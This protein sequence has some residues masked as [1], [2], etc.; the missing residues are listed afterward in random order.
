MEKTYL[1]LVFRFSDGSYLEDQDMW[2]L[3]G[4]FRDV[5]L[6]S[7]PPIRIEDFYLR[8]DFDPAYH[9]ARLL[10]DVSLIKKGSDDQELNLFV[11]LIDPN[12]K[13]VISHQEIITDWEGINVRSRSRNPL[14]KPAKWSAENPVP[15]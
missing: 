14:N 6:Y 1:A 15:L 11:E 9:D 12:G 8:C 5:Y 4:I 2:F 3:N 13:Q 7:T 10:A